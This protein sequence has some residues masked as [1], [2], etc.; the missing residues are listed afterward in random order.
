MCEIRRDVLMGQ[1][2]DVL[3]TIKKLDPTFKIELLY[4]YCSSFYGSVLWDLQLPDISCI[5]S[6]WRFA[7][8]QICRPIYELCIRVVN[9]HFSCLGSQNSV[10]SKVCQF[11]LVV[12]RASSP[13][14]RYMMFLSHRYG[15]AWQCSIIESARQV[16]IERAQF[17]LVIGFR[18]L[19]MLKNCESVH[20]TVQHFV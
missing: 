4:G 8:R 19:P 18:V 9:F 16:T 14:G 17:F 2:N 7:N 1:V 20:W 3:S 6:A 10:I 11:A 13:H 5:C 15:C 12:G